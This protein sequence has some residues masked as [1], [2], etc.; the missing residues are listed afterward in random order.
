MIWLALSMVGLIAKVSRETKKKTA[1][2]VGGVILF[3]GGLI[4]WFWLEA[5]SKAF[6][7]GEPGLMGWFI[8]G[9]AFFLVGELLLVLREGVSG[10][11][12]TAQGLAAS[13][14]A[15]GFDIFRPDDYSYVPGAILGILIILVA[16]QA[17][18]SLSAGLKK[19]AWKNRFLLALCTFVVTALVYAAT[20]KSIDRGWALP[21][22]YMAS[23]GALLFAAGQAWM[24]W[25]NILKKQVTAPWVQAA[26]IHVGQLMMMVTAFFVYK[27]FL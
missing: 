2:W 22:A 9:S 20:A 26:T 25:A 5:G 7:N 13:A 8:I 6:S 12:L 1:L 19:S 24:G 15:L 10:W 18:L 4:I 16:V 21:W 27:E 3:Y 11:A 14:F 17:Y 23:G